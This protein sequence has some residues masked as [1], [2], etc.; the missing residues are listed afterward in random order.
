LS[1]GFQFCDL[2]GGLASRGRAKVKGRYFEWRAENSGA[3]FL[4]ADAAVQFDEGVFL[5][6]DLPS[7]LVASALELVSTFLARSLFRSDY[8][9]LPVEARNLFVGASIFGAFAGETFANS[10][11]RSD[12]SR[13]AVSNSLVL[14]FIQFAMSQAREAP[15]PVPLLIA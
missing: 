13:I 8:Q 15:L 12:A 10:F 4:L 14:K 3:V 7:G 1:D 5:F 9:E 2:G 6:I 11:E